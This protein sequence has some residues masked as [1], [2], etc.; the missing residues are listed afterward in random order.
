[1]K[2]KKKSILGILIVILILVIAITVVCFAVIKNKEKG[3]EQQVQENEKVEEFVQ[4]LDDGTKLNTS[5]KLQETKIISGLK[6][7]NIQ[8]TDKNGQ[9]VLVADV[10]NESGKDTDITLLD[11][12]L[13]D[14]EGNEIVTIPGIIS[15]MKVGETR[16]LSAGITSDY[17]NAY[18]FKIVLK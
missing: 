18:D 8:L 9:S 11:I 16:Q 5:K 15:P 12:I 3:K 7:Q 6:I 14:K 13:Y 2:N 4:I 10:T 17:A 1:M